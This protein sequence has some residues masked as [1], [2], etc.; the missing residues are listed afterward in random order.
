MEMMPSHDLLEAA[1]HDAGHAVIAHHFGVS[2]G[3]VEIGM[4]GDDASGRA[5]IGCAVS[6]PFKKPPGMGRAAS[7]ATCGV[8]EGAA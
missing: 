3:E 8:Y 6:L 7:S 1:F 4:N 2:V 5:E